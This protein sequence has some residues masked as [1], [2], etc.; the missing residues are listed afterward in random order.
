MTKP[1]SHSDL[2]S[3]FE[4]IIKYKNNP[5]L[6]FL[7]PSYDLKIYYSYLEC[8]KL[9]TGYA[10]GQMDPYLQQ[11]FYGELVPPYIDVLGRYELTSI[12][13]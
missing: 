7:F 1:C 3:N 11:Y 12:F 2:P 4:P 5:A 10:A 13:H 6:E 9:N 8:L